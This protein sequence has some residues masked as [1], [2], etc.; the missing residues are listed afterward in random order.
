MVTFKPLKI[1]GPLGEPGFESLYEVFLT[2]LPSWWE[3]EGDLRENEALEEGERWL[4]VLS[5]AQKPAWD[6]ELSLIWESGWHPCCRVGSACLWRMPLITTSPSHLTVCLNAH[7]LILCSSRRL[8]CGS[9]FLMS[10]S[11]LSLSYVLMAAA[12]EVTRV[13]TLGFCTWHPPSL[14]SQEHTWEHACTRRGRRM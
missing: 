1:L 6:S 8:L 7:H 5:H 14:S 10:L 3:Y 12:E 2:L 11:R 4:I 13:S 9:S